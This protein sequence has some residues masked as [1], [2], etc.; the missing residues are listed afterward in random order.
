M[1]PGGWQHHPLS[2]GEK[3]TGCWGEPE[4]LSHGAGGGCGTPTTQHAQAAQQRGLKLENES[5]LVTGIWK[6]SPLLPWK[7]R[8]ARGLPRRGRW[9]KRRPGKRWAQRRH[10]GGG[11]GGWAHPPPGRAALGR[12]VGRG[13]TEEADERWTGRVAVCKPV[14]VGSPSG[15]EDSPRTGRTPRGSHTSMCRGGGGA[16][17]DKHRPPARPRGI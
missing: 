9:R 2:V 6:A 8:E 3:G 16:G 13:A 12:A 7:P 5:G 15:T 1:G 17:G 10:G 14:S 11:R 4:P